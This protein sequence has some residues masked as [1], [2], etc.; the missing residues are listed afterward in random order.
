MKKTFKKFILKEQR[1]YSIFLKMIDI[2]IRP[3]SYVFQLISIIFYFFPINNK[4]IV[5]SNYYGM[6]YGDNGKYIV[7]YLI[8]KKVDCII[9]W[10]LKK[11]Y[12]KDINQFP[13]NIK[14]V[15]YG[16]LRAL[17]ELST[18][19]VWIDNSRKTFY[20]L[21]RKAQ[22]YIQTWHGGIPLKK[23]EKDAENSL[24]LRYSNS[25]KNDSRMI[26]LLISNSI[27]CTDM[28]R[29]AFWYNK[30]I[31]ECGTPRCDIFFSDISKV[32]EKVQTFYG[33]D[34]HKKIV[35]Y[36]PTFR[37]NKSTFPYNI[38]FNKLS[39]CL[40]NK[41]DCEWIVLIR[42]H[43]NLA[44]EKNKIK[45]NSKVIDATD[46]DDM[47]ELMAASDMLITDY[48]STMFEYVISNKPVFIYASD[49]NEYIKDRNFYFDI[50]SL[51]FSISTKNSELVKNI[52]DFEPLKYNSDVYHFMK[53]LGVKETGN[54]SKIIAKIVEDKINEKK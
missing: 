24:S 36:A 39:L 12:L 37:K 50:K 30:Q 13:S 38:D 41:F 10:L 48:S 54:A 25:A 1:I 3:K 15:K 22:F 51:P 35:L 46:F 27:S 28:Y 53:K 44:L 16:S 49:I 52:T 29:R 6:K 33:I 26:D 31:L 40:Q 45:Y 34:Q 7:N 19:K 9:V 23:V 42:M 11:Q 8:E 2:L 17:F 14:I 47:Y 5:I 4:K 43:P 32:R 18:A 20:P 21:K